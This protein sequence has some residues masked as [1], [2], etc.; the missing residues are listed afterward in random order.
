MKT[1][2]PI[3]RQQLKDHYNT[4]IDGIDCVTF[5]H[6]QLVINSV[7]EFDKKFHPT[8]CGMQDNAVKAAVL[9]TIAVV[10]LVVFAIFN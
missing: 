3:L 9:C 6:M 7:R 5:H 1:H 2:D 8:E 10:A 4:P